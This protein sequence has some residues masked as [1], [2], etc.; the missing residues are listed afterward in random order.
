M[1]EQQKAEF[2]RNRFLRVAAIARIEMVP[3]SVEKRPPP[4]P[5]I[6]CTLN[7]GEIVALELVELVDPDEPRAVSRAVNAASIEVIGIDATTA[8]RRSL[9]RQLREAVYRTQNAM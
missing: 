9:R 6:L 1:S 8:T 4:E 7:G 2:E 3:D 5:D